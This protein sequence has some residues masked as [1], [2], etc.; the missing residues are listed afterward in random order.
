LS[1]RLGRISSEPLSYPVP[2][3]ARA[4]LGR[5]HRSEADHSFRNIA[6]RP[7]PLCCGWRAMVRRTWHGRPDPAWDASALPS[8]DPVVCWV[9]FLPGPGFGGTPR[10]LGWQ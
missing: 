1:I 4:I 7:P 10:R 3:D 9:L 6:R 8:S 5:Y 2:C